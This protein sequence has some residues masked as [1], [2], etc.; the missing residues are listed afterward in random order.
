M[1]NE[2][3][4]ENGQTLVEF[5]LLFSITMLISYVFLDLVNSNIADLWKTYIQIIIGPKAEPFE[6]N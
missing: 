4:K 5:I 2:F 3:Q 1:K 6:F